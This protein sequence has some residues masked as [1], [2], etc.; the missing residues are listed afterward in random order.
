MA[1]VK[2][3]SENNE[4]ARARHLLEK[5]DPTLLWHEYE[6]RVL[7]LSGVWVMYPDITRLFMMLGQI[8][9]QE[10]DFDEAKKYSTKGSDMV[11]VPSRLTL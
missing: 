11:D 2:F 7:G 6:L 3:K 4:L 8:T 10:N 9:F 5:F 1:A